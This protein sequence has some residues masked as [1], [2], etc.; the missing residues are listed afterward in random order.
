ME[1]RFERLDES[2]FI[3]KTAEILPGD[4]ASNSLSFGGRTQDSRFLSANGNFSISEYF[5]GTRTNYHVGI[6][7]RTGRYLNLTASVS[8]NVFDIPID[9]GAFEATTFSMN[10]N[11][12]TSRKLFAKALIQYD[13][14]S[15]DLQANIRIDWIHSPGADLFLVF[16]TSYNFIG[17]EDRFDVRSAT[18][19]NR[20][21]VAKI[22]YVIQI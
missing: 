1:R 12:A 7:L 21:G 4:Y 13:N 14:F 9:N 2:F 20:V 3:R 16:N 5:E 17:P 15:G 18:L 11:A 10:I 19:N 8:H 6:G 22:T